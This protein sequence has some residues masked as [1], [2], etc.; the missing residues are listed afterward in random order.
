MWTTVAKCSVISHFLFILFFSGS[1]F[2]N[3]MSPR[4]KF[5][6]AR[7][8]GAELRF[9]LANGSVVVSVL[10]LCMDLIQRL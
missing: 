3:S 2:L 8:W 6:T 4:R 1:S 5:S 9:T 10:L 7:G